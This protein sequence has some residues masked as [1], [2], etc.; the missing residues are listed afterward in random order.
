M[1]KL[2][3]AIAFM[4]TLAYPPLSKAEPAS[5]SLTSPVMMEEFF[6][7]LV[8]DYSKSFAQAYRQNGAKDWEADLNVI[9]L[10]TQIDMLKIKK[11]AL[12]CLKQNNLGFH[13]LPPDMPKVQKCM[14]NFITEIYETNRYVRE[15]PGGL[16]RL[17]AAYAIAP[18]FNEEKQKSPL[19]TLMFNSAKKL[20]Y[21]R[22]NIK[23]YYNEI[24]ACI[25]KKGKT[26]DER[27]E[28]IPECSVSYFKAYNRELD[29]AAAELAPYQEFYQSILN[30]APPA[31][32]N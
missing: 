10:K 2:T 11:Q 27:I 1:K 13:N 8:Y 7:T 21:S 4:I 15:N 12:K 29:K 18:Q 32:T 20:A 5:V 26:A 14:D 19:A 16:E 31:K 30:A 6:N 25:Q 9:Y 24:V 3:F 28:L 17:M 23:H 22:L